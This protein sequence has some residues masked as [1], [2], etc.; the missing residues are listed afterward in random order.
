MRQDEQRRLL[1]DLD[2]S[3]LS[4][5]RAQGDTDAVVRLTA[6]YHNLMRM[7]ADL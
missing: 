6:C 4:L 7:W 3:I 5:R 2:M 1:F